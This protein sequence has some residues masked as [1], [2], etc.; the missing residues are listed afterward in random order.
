MT[1]FYQQSRYMCIAR[2]RKLIQILSIKFL[3]C[4]LYQRILINQIFFQRIA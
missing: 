1:A 4:F 2:S 3:C